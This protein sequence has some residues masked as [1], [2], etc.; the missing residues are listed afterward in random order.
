MC[1]N[2]ARKADIFFSE[3]EA[4]HVGQSRKYVIKNEKLVLQTY[5]L[6]GKFT[7]PNPEYVIN[8]ICADQI[9]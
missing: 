4:D 6:Y 8:V 9:F 5:H 2:V 1:G 7:L 3:R